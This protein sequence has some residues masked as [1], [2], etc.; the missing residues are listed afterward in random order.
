[1]NEYMGNSATLI[2]PAVNQEAMDFLIASRNRGDDIV[3]AASVYN[4]ELAEACSRFHLLPSIHEQDFERSFLAILEEFAISRI[5]CPVS[6]VYAYLSR[7][8]ATRRLDVQMI[9]QSPVQLQIAQHRRLMNRA[10][11]LLPLVESC[12]DGRPALTLREVAGTLRQAL[13]IYGESNDDKLAAMMGIFA[14]APKGDVVEI[15][16]LMGRSTFLLLYL[17]RRY[18]IGPA[19][20]AD[21]WSALECVQ[22]DSP[23]ALQAVTDEWDY[24]VISEGFHINMLPLGTHD[25]A[26]L[27]MPS[28]RAF[29]TYTNGTAIKSQSD[30]PIQYSG[31]ISVIH[32]D[33]NHDYDS[34]N[35]DCQLWLQKMT[36][37]SWL[38]LDDYIWAHGDGPYRVGNELLDS[39]Q[40]RIQ[41][42]FV[43]GKALFVN[44]NH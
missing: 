39:Q 2:F 5:F 6:T 29:E 37:G 30:K 16:S 9:G 13:L 36:P 42:A 20:S 44:F 24:E 18:E 31:K 11:Q 40:H 3:C 10:K 22:Q 17:A 27:R 4:S 7:F 32:I 1:M 43:C 41:R 12:A 33:G 19:L 25:H 15:G 14:S 8:I 35:M 26:H 34:V 38:I 23:D 28:S 21:P